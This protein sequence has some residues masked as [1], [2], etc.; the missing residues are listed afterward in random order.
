MHNDV[1]DTEY[2]G[3]IEMVRSD[4]RFM[5]TLLEFHKK[6][7]KIDDMSLRDVEEVIM[8]YNQRIQEAYTD[9]RMTNNKEEIAYLKNFIPAAQKEC[10]FWNDRFNDKKNNMPYYHY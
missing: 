8:D 1:Y 3:P 9:L 5:G 10:M 4:T 7:K 6:R 2:L